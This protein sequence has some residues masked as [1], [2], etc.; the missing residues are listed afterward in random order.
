MIEFHSYSQCLLRSASSD[1]IFSIF[2]GTCRLAHHIIPSM[3]MTTNTVS[4]PSQNGSWS[5]RSVNGLYV[6]CSIF[7]SHWSPAIQ[8]ILYRYITHIIR[9]V[10]QI[11]KG[12]STLVYVAMFYTCP[13]YYSSIYIMYYLHPFFFVCFSSPVCRIL[14]LSGYEVL[15]RP[16]CVTSALV[17]GIA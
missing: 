12:N 14:W 7:L 4:R 8:Y 1:N 6:M 13:L 2:S 10:S 16:I 5:I 15:T 17:V 3:P 11:H 9:D